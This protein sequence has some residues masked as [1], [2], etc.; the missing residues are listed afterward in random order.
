[1]PTSPR[2][3]ARRW[4][5]SGFSTIAASSLYNFAH[6][7]AHGAFDLTSFNTSLEFV[8]APVQSLVALWAWMW[9]S[10]VEVT[11]DEQRSIMRKAF[12]GL[13]AVYLAVATSSIALLSGLWPSPVANFAYVAPWWLE[14]VGAAATFIGFVLMGR[15]FVSPADDPVSSDETA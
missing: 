8:L 7:V 1:M 10:K 11:G 3:L 9:L 6:L 2:T 13:A 15:L 4:V 14:A 12:Y 5:L